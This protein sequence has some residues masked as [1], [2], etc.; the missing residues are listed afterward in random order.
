MVPGSP[1]WH[2]ARR[3]GVGGSDAAAVCGLSPYKS[4]LGVFAE[5]VWGVEVEETEPMT[6]GTLMEPVVAAMYERK[7]GHQLVVPP[8]G[9][10][11]ADKPFMLANLDRARAA[12]DRTVECK[13]SGAWDG[14]GPSLSEDVPL[15]YFI[16]VQHQLRVKPGEFADLAA[17]I[18]G[19][20]FRWYEIRYAPVVVER[21]VQLEEEFWG[22]VERQVQPAPDF[23]HEETA[24]LLNLVRP[25]KDNLRM[26]ADERTAAL[27]DQYERL[28]KEA[29]LLA[30]QRDE[31]K[32]AII[33]AMGECSVA[34]LPDGRIVRRKAVSVKGYEVAPRTSIDFRIVKDRQP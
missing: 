1:E 14:W 9:I 7:T 18:G 20:Q 2:A 22:L 21:I 31:L 23:A 4:R 11:A 28:G 16:Q 3:K 30:K 32:A 27:V 34:S 13:T 26:A 19:N 33:A 29:S 15:H 10:A 25:P 8:Q 6:I 24:A 5:K 12:D 17:I